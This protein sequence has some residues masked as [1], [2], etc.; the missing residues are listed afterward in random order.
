MPIKIVIFLV[1][2]LKT[3]PSSHRAGSEGLL[4]QLDLLRVLEKWQSS[5]QHQMLKTLYQ[6]PWQCRLKSHKACVGWEATVLT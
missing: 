6:A 1:I 5:R 2:F 3:R 4:L